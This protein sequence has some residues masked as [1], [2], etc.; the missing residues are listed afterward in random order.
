MSLIR[1]E[2][3]YQ[4]YVW[5]GKRISSYF[6]RAL[7]MGKYAESWEVSDRSEGMS[8]VGSGHLQGKTFREWLSIEKEKAVGIGKSWE[9]FPLLVKIIDS[10]EALSVQVHPDETAAKQLG[11]EAK[12]EAWIALEKSPIYIGLKPGVTREQFIQEKDSK[13]IELLLNKIVLEK[14]ESIYIPAGQIHAICAGAF[15]LEIQQN[16]NTTYRVYDWERTGR[17]LHWKEAVTAI[18]WTALTPLKTKPRLIQAD[19]HHQRDRILSTPYF[20]VDRLE[21]KNHYQIKPDPNTCQILFCI[22]GSS[23]ID[24]Q[25][26]EPGMTYFISANA[27]L[28]SLK[29]SS[30]WFLI[31]L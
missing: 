20:S 25:K 22:E 15:L 5:G 21:I 3:A 11:G 2:P 31:R 24:N 6:Q 28:T 29:G 13:Q 4:N 9:K 18:N 12:S 16:S 23:L 10:E 17:E 19:E 14:G 8:M 30:Q 7:P 27:E 26:S 1:L